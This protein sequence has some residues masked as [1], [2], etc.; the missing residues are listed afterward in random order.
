[1]ILETSLDI[2]VK[3]QISKKLKY[4]YGLKVLLSEM[5]KCFEVNFRKT[6]V[7]VGDDRS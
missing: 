2:E 3:M 6:D 5:S 1:M 7:V 4:G